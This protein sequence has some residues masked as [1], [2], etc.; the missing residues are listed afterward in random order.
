MLWQGTIRLSGS[1][2]TSSN[3]SKH[4]LLGF[5][6]NMSPNIAIAKASQQL[7]TDATKMGLGVRVE[8]ATFSIS[9]NTITFSNISFAQ[10]TCNSLGESLM[11]TAGDACAITELWGL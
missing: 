8:E 5:K 11:F 1:A 4:K 10:F 3:L 2:V 6:F 7:V 9:G